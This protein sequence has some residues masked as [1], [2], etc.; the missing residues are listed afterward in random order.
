MTSVRISSN[1]SRYGQD[2]SI[3]K[4]QLIADEPPALG[5]DDA[6]PAPF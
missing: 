1:G 6:G 5:G 3:R 4:F 2:V